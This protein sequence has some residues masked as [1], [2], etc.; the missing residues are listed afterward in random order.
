MA[1]KREACDDW[2][3]KCVRARDTWCMRCGREDTLQAMHIVGRRNKAVRWSLDNAV[4]GCAAC[5]RYFTE[6]PIAFHDWLRSLYGDGHLDLLRE[7]SQAIL[8]T[9]EALRKEIAK[10]YREEFRRWEADDSYEIISYN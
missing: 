3:S 5:H 10:H 9:N 1:I 8:K 7:K 4:T 2:F 6:N